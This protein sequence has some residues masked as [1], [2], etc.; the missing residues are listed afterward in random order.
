MLQEATTVQWQLTHL[1]PFLIPK[2][3]VILC[4]E[5]HLVYK[6]NAKSLCRL[7]LQQHLIKGQAKS[8]TVDGK[9]I[10]LFTIMRLAHLQI[11]SF[12]HLRG[13]HGPQVFGLVPVYYL[14]FVQLYLSTCLTP[15]FLHLFLLYSANH[16]ASLPHGLYFYNSINNP[17]TL[18]V[19]Y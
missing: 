10:I 1:L 18:M 19:S 11:I 5:G 14:Y 17:Q 2:S 12:H 6:P 3:Q 8:D 16:H 4:Q 13:L 9:I 7:L 15:V